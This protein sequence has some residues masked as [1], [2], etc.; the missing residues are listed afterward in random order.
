MI[1]F[2]K[3]MM[4][5]WINVKRSLPPIGQ[6]VILKFIGGVTVGWLEEVLDENE[7]FF[8]SCEFRDWPET[9]SHWMPLPNP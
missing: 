2:L 7:P 1:L 5:K 6:T 8:Y 4:M 9:V 3:G